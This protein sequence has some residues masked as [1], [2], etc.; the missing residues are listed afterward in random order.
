MCGNHWFSPATIKHRY[1][2]DGGDQGIKNR[3][4]Q[5]LEGFRERQK[6]QPED[7]EKEGISQSQEVGKKLTWEDTEESARE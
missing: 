7:S 5:L 3:V 6:G 1:Q 2:R 4:S